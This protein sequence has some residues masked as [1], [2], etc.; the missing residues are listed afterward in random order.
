MRNLRF[1]IL[2]CTCVMGASTARAQAPSPAKPSAPKP[3]L[4]EAP[5]DAMT[6]KARALYADGLRAYEQAHFADAHAAFLAAWALEKHY[7][8][9]CNLGDVEMRLARHREAAQHLRTC[10]GGM[11]ND[12]KKTAA[13][14]AETAALL[15][16]ARGKLLTVRVRP[17]VPA[18]VRADGQVTGDAEVFLDAGKHSFEARADGYEVARTEIEG[19]EGETRDV[20]L[21]LKKIASV[22]AASAR[23][24]VQGPHKEIVIAGAAVAGAAILAGAI[25]AGLAGSKAGE[26]DGKGGWD[27]CYKAPR[28]PASVSC[29]ELD[30]IRRDSATFTNSA[31]WS[32]IGGAVVGGA[33]LAYALIARSPK[34]EA[35]SVQAVPL[36][37][38]HGG[39]L[40]L[41]GNF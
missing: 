10:A 39:G 30:G 16:G 28:P 19:R 15:A 21:E 8:I 32:F 7:S 18:E 31:G 40:V 38:A 4:I 29:R 37:G 41:Q 22:P 9:A 35:P 27:Q 5:S 14:K 36:V 26:A 3:S 24:T 6:Q 2:L 23:A 20:A 12:P 13:E 1:S 11:A 25:F 17:S 33:T 34:A